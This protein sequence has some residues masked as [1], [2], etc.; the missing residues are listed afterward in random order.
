MIS[1]PK[2]KE[3]VAN[4]QSDIEAELSINIPLLGKN[5]IRAFS[6]TIAGQL[7]LI[8]LQIGLL[9]KNIF[10]DTATSEIE[11]GTLERWGRIKLG[12]DP[13]K[14]QS[15]QYKIEVTGT[16]GALVKAQTTFKSNDD[17]LHPGILYVLDTD[18]TLTAAIDY[19]TVRA[20]TSGI[21][22][23]LNMGNQMT[24]TG[25]VAGLNRIVTVVE[26]VIAPRA[27]ES[28]DDYR[29]KATESF[30]L[31][32]EG[33]ARTDFRLWS[34]D[35]QGVK[36]TY[37]Y[38]TSGK[39]A[40]ADLFIEATIEDSIDGKG[41]PDDSLLPDV[42]ECIEL[43][44]DTTLPPL[45]RGRRPM[46]VHKVNYKKITIKNV[47]IKVLGFSGI[48]TDISNQIKNA[49]TAEISKIRPFIAGVDLLSMKND[50]LDINKITFVILTT[51]PGS[52]FTGIELRVDGVLIPSYQFIGGNIPYLNTVIYG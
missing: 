6:A 32:P 22:G 13:Y 12:R 24:V 18:F 49:L 39:S 16:V 8:Y 2:L 30:R 25:P 36:Q 14:A 35:V 21:E 40:E 31:E 46:G 19:I 38:A 41:T 52:I 51:R 7:K 9:Q 48:T 50:I 17:S 29:N 37:P 42:E 1:I 15:G 27:A 43:D 11:G 28:I 33:G 44:P 34:L 3:L 5:W 45:E 10:V 26:E 47:D 4:I 23:K 20:L